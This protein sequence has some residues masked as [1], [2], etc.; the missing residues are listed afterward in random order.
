M[1]LRTPSGE[2]LALVEVRTPW[3]TTPDGGTETSAECFVELA[4][5]LLR[6]GYQRPRRVGP[7]RVLGVGVAG[8]AES[9]V[10]L[11][12]AGRPCT[13]VVAWFDR[14]GTA[15]IDS[16]SL[17]DNDFGPE[18]VR[19]TGLPWDCQASVAKLLWLSTAASRSDP[20]H[21]WVSMPEWVVHRLGGEL[22][23]E[24]SLASRTGLVDQGTG[25]PWAD[26]AAGSACRPRCCRPVTIR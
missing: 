21:R 10:L 16:I 17:R 8:L 11:D 15:Q 13:P 22:V 7:L 26:G 23:H 20:A 14:R 1:L 19:R 25:T 18:F 5:D 6:R 12:G 24:P 4:I 2:Q 3:T 9:G